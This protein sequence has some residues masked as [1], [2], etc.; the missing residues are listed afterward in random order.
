M[1]VL[2]AMPKSQLRSLALQCMKYAF[3]ALMFL[4]V[5][6]PIDIVPDVLVGVGWL[7]D[8][9]YIAAGVAAIKSGNKDGRQRAFDQACENA[10][11]ARDLEGMHNDPSQGGVWTPKGHDNAQS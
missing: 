7:D 8:L 4:L 9:G 11:M 1:L 5:P 6:S 2:F 3:G 10:R